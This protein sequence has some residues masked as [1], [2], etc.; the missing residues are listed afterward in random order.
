MDEYEISYDELVGYE[1][2]DIQKKQSKNIKQDPDIYKM[3]YKE[4]Q[5][6]IYNKILE[7]QSSIQSLLEVANRKW[8]YYELYQN[9][10]NNRKQWDKPTT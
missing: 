2:E 7:L 1:W 6:L 5:C 10:G 3:N 8:N 4:F 9:G